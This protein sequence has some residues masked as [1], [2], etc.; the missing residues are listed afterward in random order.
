MTGNGEKKELKREN[1]F[2]RWLTP[3]L[4]VLIGG[5]LINTFS[6]WT[7]T[8]ERMEKTQTEMLSKLSAVT[9]DVA[10]NRRDIDRHE[11]IIDK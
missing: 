10:A 4:L 3:S 11:R 5:L 1:K 8:L 6:T 7:T 9:V 2:F